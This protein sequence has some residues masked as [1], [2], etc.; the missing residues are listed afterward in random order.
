MHSNSTL[1]LLGRLLV[2]WP[3]MATAIAEKIDFNRQIR[4]I[5]SQ[6][7]F[8]CHG[9]DEHDRKAGLRLDDRDAAIADRNGVRAIVPGETRK[10]AV[11]DRILSENADEL[12][13]PPGSHKTLTAEEKALLSQWIQEGAAYADH[14]SFVPPKRAAPPEPLSSW[15][16]SPIDA[17]ILDQLAKQGLQP[18]ERTDRQTWLRRATFD[19]TGLPPEPKDLESFTEDTHSNAEARQLDRLLASYR[20]GERMALAWMDA[21]RY[22]DSSV[23]HADGHRDMWPWRDWVI[24]AYNENKPFDEFTVEQLAGDLL[25]DATTDQK[26]ASG[27]NRNHAT[28]DEGG[29]IAEELRIDYV[30]D[31][32]KTTANVWLALSMECG[33]CHDH[34]YDPISQHEY[35]QFFAYFNNTSD[36]GMQTRNGNQAPLVRLFSP[37]QR[38]QLETKRA[39]LASFEKRR[40]EE[41]APQDEV[42]QWSANVRKGLRRSPPKLSE[43]QWLGSFKGANYSDAFGKDFGPEKAKNQNSKKKFDGKAWAPGESWQ[44]GE[45]HELPLEENEVGYLGRT[46]ETDKERKG[47]LWLGCNDGIKVW[48]DGKQ[49][50]SHQA[51]RVAELDQ[52]KVEVTLK[53]GKH[54]LLVKIVNSGNSAGFAFRWES[55]TFPENI[56]SLAAK[57]PKDLTQMEQD[58]LVRFYTKEVWP[59]GTDL[60]RS[61]AKAKKDE[62]RLVDSAP[63]S[64]VMEDQRE[65]PRVTYILSRGQYDQPLKD[66]PVEP[67]VPKALPTFPKNAPNNRLGLARWLTV[68]DHPLTSR[69]AVNRLLGPAI[70]SRHRPHGRRLRKSRRVAESSGFVRLVSLGLCQLWMGCETL[71]TT[72][73]TV[74]DLRPVF[75]L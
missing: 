49:I 17:F 63:T 41:R 45:I 68:P 59:Q 35:Y 20:Y 8:A 50:H 6:N 24:N 67:G 46:L 15:G 10:S 16:T 60:D 66:Q 4:P 36:P 73:H 26:V 2:C 32:V 25:P 64:M 37:D 48:L 71:V 21:A 7:C 34:K 51:N 56:V 14:W 27:F 39:T 1:L 72:N 22:G 12:M 44:D 5:L 54:W 9:P 69:V 70:R 52:D 40:S 55:Q 47:T 58:E 23:M 42:A 61:I 62:K 29:A 43:W 11:I 30:V 31:R 13:P 57:L 74:G 53:P 33:Q 19:L 65:K 75:A 3:L 38:R 18:S 28:S